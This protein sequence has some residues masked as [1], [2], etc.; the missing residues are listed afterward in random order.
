MVPRVFSPP[1]TKVFGYVGLSSP[2][3]PRCT[4]FLLSLLDERLPGRFL[5]STSVFGRFWRSFLGSSAPLLVDT[6][7]VPFTDWF[8]ESGFPHHGEI[9]AACFPS[10]FSD[11]RRI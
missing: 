3:R 8:F 6:F 11:I 2:F 4:P 9:K 10:P 1:C 7:G 5:P